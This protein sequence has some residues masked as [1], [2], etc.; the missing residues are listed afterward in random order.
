[1]FQAIQ[2]RALQAL[3]GELSNVKVLI[4]IQALLVLN[5]AQFLLRVILVWSLTDTFC[6]DYLSNVHYS[7]V[8]SFTDI[9]VWIISQTS[10][11]QWFGASQ[12]FL[13]WLSLQ[14]SII[15]C[16]SI[17]DLTRE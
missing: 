12:T 4:C 17:N 10:T 11:I 2:T 3:S 5:I 15:Q 9:F 6:L 13:S 7:M 8:W 14:K 16:P 1:M